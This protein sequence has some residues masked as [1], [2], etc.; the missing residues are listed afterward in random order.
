MNRQDE[1]GI[2]LITTLI[3]LSLVTFLSV[4][5]LTLTRQERATVQVQTEITIAEE[6][7]RGAVDRAVSDVF[8]QMLS[9]NSRHFY[10]F[11]VSTN[12]E[13]PGGLVP[14]VASYANAS[15]RNN[16]AGDYEGGPLNAADT[17]RNLLNLH[18]DPRVPVYVNVDRSR[19]ASGR[20]TID[21]TMGGQEF[22]HFVD[23]NRNGQFEPTRLVLNTNYPGGVETVTAG[24][25][26]VGDPHWLGI[27]D[28]P[29]TNH[30]GTNRFVGRYAYLVMPTS[31][32]LDINRIHNQAR[33]LGQSSPSAVEEGYR[34]NHGVGDWELNMAGFLVELNGAAWNRTGSQY[35][36]QLYFANNGDAFNHARDLSRAR[37]QFS[38]SDSFDFGNLFSFADQYPLGLP[39]Q[40]SYFW[41]T[42]NHF[43]MYGNGPLALT[44]SLSLGLSGGTG[45]LINGDDL[46]L[47]DP[48]GNNSPWFASPMPSPFF[49]IQ[50]LL[51][52]DPTVN[53]VYQNFTDRLRVH[54]AL[55]GHHDRYTFYRLM[56]QMGTDSK[57]PEPNKFNLNYLN[58][59]PE[60]T[61]QNINGQWT[62][63][64]RP[65]HL[66]DMWPERQNGFVPWLQA[67][68][69]GV[70]NYFFGFVADTLLKKRFGLSFQ[71]TRANNQGLRSTVAIPVWDSG[72]R[73]N[74]YTSAVHQT[75]QLA[76]NIYDA[77]TGQNYPE[78]QPSVGYVVGNRV[79]FA[80]LAYETTAGSTAGVSPNREPT[81]W[82]I[83][84]HM[85]SVFR[86]QFDVITN[87]MGGVLRVQI[88]NYVH[89]F[90]TNYLANQW[91]DLNDSN[92]NHLVVLRD[93]MATNVV[94]SG[95]NAN[96]LGVSLVVGAKKGL[97][98]FNE[99]GLLSRVT[100]GRK[101]E[102]TKA[103][104]GTNRTFRTNLMYTLGIT[105][106]IV[107]EAW[108]SYTQAYPNPLQIHFRHSVLGRITNSGGVV[109]K[110]FAPSTFVTNYTLGAG[111]LGGGF[112]VPLGSRTETLM[113]GSQFVRSGVPE[114][115]VPIGGPFTNRTFDRP[116]ISVFD[117]PDWHFTATHRMAFWIVDAAQNQVI[118][119][120][121][122]ND[123]T[124]YFDLTRELLNRT[125]LSGL[126]ETNRPGG[127]NDI[128]VPTFGVLEQLLY[129][130]G[131]R[132]ISETEWKG[133]EDLAPTAEQAERFRT[134]F[135]RSDTRTN[136]QAPFQ[137]LRSLFTSTSWGAN[138]P[139]VHYTRQDLTDP[140]RPVI[141]E[142]VE[143]PS[144][145]TILTNTFAGLN[146]RYNPWGGRRIPGRIFGTNS[147]PEHI[148]YNHTIKDP[149]VRWSDDW[150]FPTHKMAHAGWLGRIH[151]G[152]HWQTV[153]LK[154]HM[155]PLIEPNGLPDLSWR[156]WAGTSLT[157]PTNDWELMDLFTAAPVPSAARGLLS[158]NQTNSAAWYAALSG[159][160]LLTNT[161]DDFEIGPGTNGFATLGNGLGSYVL[162]PRE[163]AVR[164]I[165]DGI[166]RYRSQQK[167]GVFTNLGQILGVAELSIGE[168]NSNSLNQNPVSANITNSSPVIYRGQLG[169]EFYSDQEQNGIPDYVYERLPQQLMGLLKMEDHPQLTIYTWGQALKPA[170]RS[171][172]LTAGPL[173]GLVTNY[174]VTAEVSAKSS[175][176]IEGVNPVFGFGPNSFRSLYEI[177]T[178]PQNI[179]APNPPVYDLLL[180][181]RI[182]INK[183]GFRL[184]HSQRMMA[185]IDG[186]P[187]RFYTGTT[188]GDYL[189]PPLE[190]GRIYYV[191][192]ARADD[193]QISLTQDGNSIV[194]L[195][196]N[197]FGQG[198]HR[199]TTV[200]R[201]VI[202]D[203]NLLFA[204]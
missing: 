142:V 144:L 173:R 155:A 103:I 166:H 30:T 198:V 202:E 94:S 3:M 157:H 61:S 44:P 128:T 51:K 26:R 2:A 176:R 151:R 187:I 37:Y 28:K 184:R 158:I 193:F 125:S 75:L 10:N 204:E 22:R 201:A 55:A 135:N 175:V 163:V 31:K 35:D 4:A 95:P 19:D 65:Q 139:L 67:D 82:T 137:A 13:R 190:A 105:N 90:G 131:Y 169:D 38:P 165:V 111:V 116:S 15:Y 76:A 69:N 17:V 121:S 146:R 100:I 24:L 32:S 43:D 160:M 124:S 66:L 87:A 68:I 130:G 74:L 181:N 200:P 156:Q 107:G 168:T 120:V 145:P 78:W 126:W 182:R 177:R 115:F 150:N 109:L 170:R 180:Q 11:I 72:T 80:G 73:S 46:G 29:Y 191:A 41:Q 97:P 164:T 60:N 203:H 152:T 83:L 77:T 12:Y 50:E 86:P 45:N 25:L 189:P 102:V 194:N 114:Y 161:I 18:D 108:N 62:N 56:A 178:N 79:L 122:L 133:F 197:D 119:V 47:L 183:I 93:A 129:A 136:T 153:Y 185:R 36:Y 117:S 147:E 91:L 149:G 54:G 112:F 154:A 96:L 14:G 118:D 33:L 27:L 167:N 104:S 21:R 172:I 98:N 92:N 70:T 16:S 113:A 127:T 57:D 20:E 84:P 63:Y 148:A 143:P 101:I 159:L 40:P 1:R 188:A 52:Q 81:S 6:I 8:T 99:L 110:E 39:A 199:V 48:T 134:F 106:R 132:G 195:A 196:N 89:Q 53:T 171:V 34:R 138:D 174:Q 88:T 192:N 49:D 5:F 71:D 9:T 162:D 140:N 179:A 64:N 141:V 42:A 123:L 186:T 58:F 59:L 7:G 85:P 23:F